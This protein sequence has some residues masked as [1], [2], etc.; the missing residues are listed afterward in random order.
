MKID[1]AVKTK[2]GVQ[3]VVKRWL[4]KAAAHPFFLSDAQAGTN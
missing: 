3:I 1:K 2:V 4:G